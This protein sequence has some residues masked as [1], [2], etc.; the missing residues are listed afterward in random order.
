MQR[1]GLYV[2][3][4]TPLGCPTKQY[5]HVHAED[6]QAHGCVYV[7]AMASTHGCV[8]R[9]DVPYMDCLILSMHPLVASQQPHAASLQECVH[10][11]RFC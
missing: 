7:L 5:N 1:F 10:T 4:S 11:N 8:L 3:M 6:Q 9:W 2:D